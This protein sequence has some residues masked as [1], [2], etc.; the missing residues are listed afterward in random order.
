MLAKKLASA[1]NAVEPNA[2]FP[3]HQD[4]MLILLP[5]LVWKHVW[6]EK[7]KR[8]SR[9]TSPLKL[10]LHLRPQLHAPTT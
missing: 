1:G 9:T 6:W 3:A 7:A 10:G 4:D 5:R 2:V 8:G